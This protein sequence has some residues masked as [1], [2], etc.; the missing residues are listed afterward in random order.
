MEI[1]I[2][3]LDSR[4]TDHDL[5]SIIASL[6]LQDSIQVFHVH[7]TKKKGCAVLTIADI[8]QANCVLDR[9]G[10][11]PDA[12]CFRVMNKS[13]SLGISRNVPDQRLL[14]SLREENGRLLRQQ[15]NQE[16]NEPPRI[17]PSVPRNLG[18]RMLYC[19]RWEVHES[20]LHYVAFG[21]YKARGTIRV[22]RWSLNLALEGSNNSRTTY[23]VSIDFNDM[24]SI[25][26]NPEASETQVTITLG[27][28]P[29]IY[30]QES[31]PP[32][33]L[34]SALSALFLDDKFSEP[35]KY[36]SRVLGSL[37]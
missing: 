19:G 17:T 21:S 23:D 37:S 26:I 16:H 22:D 13:I 25:A 31:E 32:Q 14:R 8:S 10:R 3:N 15:S 9:Y 35:Q 4:V 7:K 28:A 11:N 29:K 12:P 34:N 36:R 1:F 6:L 27:I 18:F 24:Q 33:D 5:N 2:R 20:T 30:E